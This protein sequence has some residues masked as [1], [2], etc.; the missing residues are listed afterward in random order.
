MSGEE[1]VVEQM[2][3]E[4]GVT[5]A[6]LGVNADPLPVETL[7][8]DMRLAAAG[9]RRWMPDTLPA[10]EIGQVHFGRALAEAAAEAIE[11][12]LARIMPEVPHEPA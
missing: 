3:I 4:D 11:A 6:D 8:E 7:L 5:P 2:E 1:V 9:I 12:Y 10:N